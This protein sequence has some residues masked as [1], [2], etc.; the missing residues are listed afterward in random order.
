MRKVTPD[1]RRW[2]IIL[3]IDGSSS[4]EQYFDLTMIMVANLYVNV[5]Q[6]IA[7]GN[8]LQIVE[9]RGVDTR[10]V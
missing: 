1:A 4:M 9:M 8:T 6:L 10:T 2:E 7:D 3:C 5:R